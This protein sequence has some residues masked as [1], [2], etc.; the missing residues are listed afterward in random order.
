MTL[1]GEQASGD[2][3]RDG[4]TSGAAKGRRGG[5]FGLR[6]QGGEAV[7]VVHDVV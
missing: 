6:R 1:K 2:P 4:K 7:G 5:D 3:N